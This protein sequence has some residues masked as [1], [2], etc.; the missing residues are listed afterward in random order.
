MTT[1]EV[2]TY[3]ARIGV[4]AMPTREALVA[5]GRAIQSGKAQVTVAQVN[6]GR[7]RDVYTARSQRHLLDLLEASPSPLQVPVGHL[8]LDGCLRATSV[9]LQ[10]AALLQ[11]LR[12]AIA[13]VF[14]V[15]VSRVVD[16]RLDAMGLDSILAIE[17]RSILEA[18]LGISVT[19]SVLWNAESAEALAETLLQIWREADLLRAVIADE[20]GALTSHELEEVTI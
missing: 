10:Q 14:R 5:L 15:D 17:L 8:G 16:G 7:F 9:E 13:A 18:S 19:P 4:E 20:S 1:P 12:L 6:W 2:A 3:H 11:G